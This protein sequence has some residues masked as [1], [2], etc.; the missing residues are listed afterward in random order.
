MAKIK[1]KI[2]AFVDE[3]RQALFTG[4]YGAICGIICYE[5]GLRDGIKSGYLKGAF[6]G[7]CTALYNIATGK[8]GSK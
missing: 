3:N 7:Y 2:I 5:V 4:L 1:E 6:N 8:G